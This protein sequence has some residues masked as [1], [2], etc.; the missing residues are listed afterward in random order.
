MIDLSSEHPQLNAPESNWSQDGTSLA[1]KGHFV[2]EADT[3]PHLRAKD[4]TKSGAMRSSLSI[5]CLSSRRPYGTERNCNPLSISAKRADA[6]SKRCR[7]WS[8]RGRL[9]CWN[10]VR[11]ALDMICTAVRLTSLCRRL[12]RRPEAKLT[13]RADV[14]PV[15]QILGLRIH[16]LVPEAT[17]ARRE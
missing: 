2:N 15:N 5:E 17:S 12:S 10:L 1:R 11:P 13:R 16:Y 7:H 9:P 3:A 8:Q 14:W 6:R 4:K